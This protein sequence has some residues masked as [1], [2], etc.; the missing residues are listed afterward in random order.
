M[1]LAILVNMGQISNNI[2]A[3]SIYY[4]ELDTTNFETTIRNA[5][6]SGGVSVNSVYASDQAATELAGNG[7]KY[8]VSGQNCFAKNSS[9]ALS[10]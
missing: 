1:V 2:V 10:S 6:N 5:A 9:F 8:Q 4:T 3:R 7:L